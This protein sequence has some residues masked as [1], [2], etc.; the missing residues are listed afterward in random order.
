MAAGGGRASTQGSADALESREGGVAEGRE[1]ENPRIAAAWGWGNTT[2]DKN[3]F[4]PHLATPPFS[5]GFVAE[6]SVRNIHMK[7]NRAGLCAPEAQPHASQAAFAGS[8]ADSRHKQ[9]TEKKIH[10]WG[11]R[12][13]WWKNRA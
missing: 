11:K 5:A 9:E 3:Y 7:K 12:S 2:T 10:L 6:A 13:T 4:L 1:W 8:F